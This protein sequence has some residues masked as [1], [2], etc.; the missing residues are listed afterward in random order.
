MLQLLGGFPGSA[1]DDEWEICTIR[2]HQ[3][4]RMSVELLPTDWV[5]MGVRAP[6]PGGLGDLEDLEGFPVSG[7]T[8]Y[9]LGVYLFG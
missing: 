5:T 1:S 9:P 2:V 6:S 8:A 7:R 4:D 3:A